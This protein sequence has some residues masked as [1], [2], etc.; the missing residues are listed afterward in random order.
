MPSN[1][2]GVEERGPGRQ[3]HA[4]RSAVRR[5]QGRDVAVQSDQDG[6]LGAF[7]R[8]LFSPVAR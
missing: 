1:Q 8:A 3:L 2:G 6:R 5:L 4:Q 7:F